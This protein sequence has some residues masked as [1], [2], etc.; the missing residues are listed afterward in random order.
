MIKQLIVALDYNDQDKAM[1]LINQLSPHHCAVKIGSEMFTLFGSDFVSQVVR[2]GF[3]VFLDLKF[4]DIP[5]TVAQACAAAADLGVWMINIHA[6]GGLPMMCAAREALISYGENKPLLIAVTLLTSMTTADLFTIGIHVSLEKQVEHLA[7]LAIKANLDGIVC[8]AHE[9]PLIKK[10]AG[11]SF[12]TVTPG[13]RLTGDAVNDQS[14]VATVK[15]A[16]HLGSDYLV[17]GRPITQ[18]K[19]PL[20]V[21]QQILKDFE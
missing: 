17:I 11:S 4:H 14:R 12:L 13:I 16:A 21:I 5:T 2:K 3:K 6:L 8:S 9:V 10:M 19:D 7:I 1:G 20:K 15:E 18:A